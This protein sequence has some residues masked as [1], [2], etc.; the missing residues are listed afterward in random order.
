MILGLLLTHQEEIF[1]F[2]G[3]EVGRVASFF[4]PSATPTG[5]VPKIL[6]PRFATAEMYYLISYKSHFLLVSQIFKGANLADRRQVE[7]IAVVYHGRNIK[8]LWGMFQSPLIHLLEEKNP[9][10]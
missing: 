6:P 8:Q 10:L 5:V 3:K 7:S 4:F 9:I 1:R 2:K